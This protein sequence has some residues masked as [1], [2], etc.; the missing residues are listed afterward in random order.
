MTPGAFWAR[1]VSIRMI[2]AW[3]TG[4]RQSL[5]CTIPGTTT[6]LMKRARPVAFSG[7]STRL[8]AVPTVTSALGAAR[9]AERPPDALGSHRQLGEAHTRRLGERVADRR[10][11]A[12]R[13]ALADAL[14][15]EWSRAVGVLDQHGLERRR[16]VRERR[17]TVVDEPGIQELA[18]LVHASLEER[19]TDSLHRG[20]LV[21]RGAL[22][23]VDRLAHVG[24]RDVFQQRDLARLAID[25]DL[26]RAHAA[27]PEHRGAA[28][29]ARR[30][31][32]HERSDTGD[33]TADE[34]IVATD[35]LSHRHRAIAM[36]DG[37]V[38][39]RQRRG[40][41]LEQLRAK[42]QQLLTRVFRRR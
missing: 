22:A 26:S 34:A 14:G 28:E 19:G 3:G 39:D 6:S 24:G 27:L 9:V 16:E 41:G 20:A 12:E 33:F 17:H 18:V 1:D 4:L 35:D 38:A 2:L 15:A 42:G 29:R 25:V 31:P 40:L 7:V 32:R 30:L 23:R 37:A 13:P 36:R 8:A 11:H 5:A 10:S 21:L